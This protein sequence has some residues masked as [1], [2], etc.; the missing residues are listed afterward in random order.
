M[1]P[2]QNDLREAQMSDD[3]SLI[4]LLKLLAGC[5]GDE[6]IDIVSKFQSGALSIE[7]IDVDEAQDE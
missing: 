7:G 2:E 5:T 6:A 1:T 4:E 3:I